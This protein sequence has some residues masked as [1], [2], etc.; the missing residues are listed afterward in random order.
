[1]SNLCHNLSV[2]KK[3]SLLL[4]LTTK[5]V[6][7]NQI[8]MLFVKCSARAHLTPYTLAAMTLLD[9]SSEV[10]LVFHISPGVNI[11]N[12]VSQEPLIIITTLITPND[13]KGPLYVRNLPL[14][15]YVTCSN[16]MIS[17]C[18]I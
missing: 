11:T 17:D 5:Y 3:N 2:S 10:P 8:D 13:H 15:L 18:D 9:R 1:M 4:A 6:D 12:R 16:Y 7:K 14:S